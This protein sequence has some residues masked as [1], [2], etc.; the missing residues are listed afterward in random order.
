MKEVKPRKSNSEIEECAVSGQFGA[1]PLSYEACLSTLHVALA[2]IAYR[3]GKLP[4]K[5]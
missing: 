1:T 5:A 4:L 2:I 3:A